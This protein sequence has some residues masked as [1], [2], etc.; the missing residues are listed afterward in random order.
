MGNG[1]PAIQFQRATNSGIGIVARIVD[2]ATGTG[3]TTTAMNQCMPEVNLRQSWN[4]RFKC[5][6]EFIEF[7]KKAI[8]VLVCIRKICICDCHPIMRAKD[9]PQLLPENAVHH[10]CHQHCVSRWGHRCRQQALNPFSVS[11]TD[12]QST[13]AI[14]LN[15][16][17]RWRIEGSGTIGRILV[18]LHNTTRQ[19]A[20]RKRWR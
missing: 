18:I 5:R 8:G 9:H 11:P 7:R 13:H 10:P 2:T 1:P 16:S 4:A 12:V 19:I 6:H 14:A 17:R 15:N 3:Q 20:G